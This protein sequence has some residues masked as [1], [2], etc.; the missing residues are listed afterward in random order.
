MERKLRLTLSGYEKY[1]SFIVIRSDT[2]GDK[3]DSNIS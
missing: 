2:W 1:H 3:N